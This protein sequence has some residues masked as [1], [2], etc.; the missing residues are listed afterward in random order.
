M[1]FR[2]TNMPAVFMDTMNRVFHD[3]LDQLTIVFIDDILI[4]SKTPKEHEEH[5][6][7]ALERLLRE[8]LSA[9]LE[10]CEFWLDSMS[11]LR[12][13]VS[14][15]GAAIDPKKVKAMVEWTRPTSVFEI[16]SFLGLAGYY[17]RFIEGFSKLLEP[18]DRTK[19]STRQLHESFCNKVAVQVRVSNPQRIGFVIINSMPK[20]ILP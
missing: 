11:F 6:R 14:G 18:L 20:L 12:D 3:Y 5:L 15:K 19:N 13:V 10:K 7:K 16:Q 2:L 4:Y 1:S 17:R 9:K 8:K